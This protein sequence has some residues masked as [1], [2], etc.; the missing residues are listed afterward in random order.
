M[1]F[2]NSLS[3]KKLAAE[4][5]SSKHEGSLVSLVLKDMSVV[6]QDMSAQDM[7]VQGTLA[8]NQVTVEVNK[9]SVVKVFNKHK[10]SSVSLALKDTSVIDKVSAVK[11]VELVENQTKERSYL[12]V[13]KDNQLTLMD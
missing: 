8:A 4:K 11:Q 10:I 12:E 13:I 7:L 3:R 2:V 5:I 9:E 6:N 1:N